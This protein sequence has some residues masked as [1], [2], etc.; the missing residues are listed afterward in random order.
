MDKTIAQSIAAIAA[1]YRS[2]AAEIAEQGANVLLHYAKTSAAKTAIAFRQEIL[3]IS[4]TLIRSHPSMAPLV[5]LV[6]TLLWAIDSLQSLTPMK[7]RAVNAVADFKH[8]IY[9]REA[10]IAGLVLKLIPER[11]Q[12]V[13]LSRSTTVKAALLYAQHAGRRFHV[14]CAEG[15]PGYEGRTMAMELNEHGVSVSL[16]IDALAISL[17]QEANL[18]LVGSDHVRD[19]ELVNKAGTYGM[20]LA[21]HA[22]D[23]P[24]YTLCGSSKFLPPG[25]IPPSQTCWDSSQVWD[26]PPSNI[27]IKNLYFDHTPLSYIS[28]I[29]TEKGVL[30]TVGIEA[31][32]ASMKLHPSLKHIKEE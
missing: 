19:H 13:T 25:Y 20:A 15:R 31:W 16:V 30:P 7:K 10:A 29:V 9:V 27:A 5:N 1:D 21:S 6:N 28:G 11:A 24:M 32:L 4:Y 3:S 8:Q 18:V 14:I 12:I 22:H 23:V 17:T 26:A 2:G